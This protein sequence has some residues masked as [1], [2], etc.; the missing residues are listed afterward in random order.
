MP[1][2]ILIPGN[3]CDARLWAAMGRVLDEARIAWSVAPVLAAP[4][5]AAMAADVLA[6]MPDRAVPVGFSMGA[7]VVLEMIRQA[8]ERIAAAAFVALNAGADLPERAAAR[9]R[10]QANVRAGNLAQVVA[11]ELKPVY[12]AAANRD[13]PALRALTL[14]MAMALGVEIFVAQSEALRTRPDLRPVLE[15]LAVPSLFACGVE[16]RLCPPEWHRRWAGLAGPGA[17]LHIVEGAGHLLPIEQP[18]ALGAALVDWLVTKE[19][20]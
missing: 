5:I 16:D 3:M 19:I 11:D 4:S 10:Q 17:T 1:P 20:A 6:A 9:P 18:Q 2:L 15:G 14:D 7:I 12:F 8:P 13:D